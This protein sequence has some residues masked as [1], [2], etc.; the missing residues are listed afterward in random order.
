MANTKQTT[1]EVKISQLPRISD[2][3]DNDLLIVS[4]NVGN[5]CKSKSMTLQQ[6][7]EFVLA[8]ICSSSRLADIIDQKVESSA[9]DVAE[10]AAA[11]AVARVDI[12]NTV[13][14]MVRLSSDVVLDLLDGVEDRQVTFDGNN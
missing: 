13:I 14:N 6:L 12:P 1:K 4:D 10:A 3:S 11:D 7:Y 8:K 2:I 9:K 5:T